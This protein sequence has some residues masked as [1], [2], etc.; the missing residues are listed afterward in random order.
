MDIF[1]QI[2]GIQ[3]QAF[4][5][6][7]LS[8]FKSIPDLNFNSLPAVFILNTKRN[9]YAVSKWVSPKR[10][11]SY[12][13]TRVYDTLG[14]AKKI[15][16]IPLIKDE[17]ID[18]DRDFLQWD[19]IAMM[20][21]LD[22]YVVVAYYDVAQKKDEKQKITNQQFNNQYIYSK[23]IEIENYQSSALHWNLQQLNPSNLADLCTKTQKSYTQI[24]QQ[25]KVQSHNKQGI[26][27]FKQKIE[28]DIDSFKQFSRIKA[29][30]AQNREFQTI[31]PKEKLT[32][33]SKAK[34][35]LTNYLGGQYFLTVDEVV[36]KNNL[37]CLME[38][39]HTQRDHFPKLADIKDGLLKLILYANL[40]HVQINGK[41][42]LT[43]AVLQLTSTKIIGKVSSNDKQTEITHFLNTNKF[44]L[45]TT[46]LIKELFL[47]AKTNNFIVQIQ[48][49]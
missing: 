47:G 19:T 40:S 17:G 22:V 2:T 5:V 1:G 28:Q 3:H 9:S 42:Y 4:L 33:L 35:T 31:Q 8:K 23:I 27:K 36:F 25:T 10:T 43:K 15:T 44:N 39:K 29:G 16:I 21:L 6:P 45:K 24:S 13:F 32:T 49:I 30:Q 14:Y 46:Q 18:G 41:T 11:R 20:S 34:I 38:S 48:Q 7:N 26:V 12:P 37:I